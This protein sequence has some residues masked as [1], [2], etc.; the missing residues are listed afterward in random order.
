MGAHPTLSTFK[1]ALRTFDCT[2]PALAMIE[3][4]ANLVDASIDDN[5]PQHRR[6]ATK[7]NKLSIQVLTERPDTARQTRKKGD[8]PKFLRIYTKENRDG[9]ARLDA[10]DPRCPRFEMCL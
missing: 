7:K 9:S 5:K 6:Y 3:R 10:D 2:L 8:P 4:T 1:L